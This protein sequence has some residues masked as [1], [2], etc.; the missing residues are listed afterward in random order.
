MPTFEV[1]QQL[2]TV[3]QVDVGAAH[4][5]IH[6]VQQR[7]TG[8]QLRLWELADFDRRVRGREDGGAVGGHC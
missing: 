1:G 7:G 5:G 3:P 6:G 2:F 8:F 4:L